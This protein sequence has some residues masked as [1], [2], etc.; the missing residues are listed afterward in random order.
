MRSTR[1]VLTS[2]ALL[3]L[4]APS[5]LARNP[6]T[7]PVDAAYRKAFQE[8][9]LARHNE[10]RALHGVPPLRW[11]DAIAKYAESRARTRAQE[12]GLSAG[13]SGLASGYGENLYWGGSS[14]AGS[15]VPSA[16]AI[17][18]QATQSWYNELKDYSYAS[19]G[20]SPQ[21][22]HFTQM[23]WK[24]TTEV[25]C[26]VLNVKGSQWL[27]T[28]VVCD[29]QPPGNVVGQFPANVPPRKKG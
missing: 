1:L 2:A 8:A 17:V 11:S 25:G 29:Y 3:A 15:A 20:F 4:A 7:L 16:K 27:E 18:E 23:V 21:V 26:A 12:E 19:P 10:Y 9:I 28:Y 5:A 22:G 14:G 6:P 13:H 24:G